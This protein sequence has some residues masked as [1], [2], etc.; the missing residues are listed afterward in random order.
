MQTEGSKNTLGLCHRN[1]IPTISR[2][3]MG[4]R[5]VSAITLGHAGSICPVVLESAAAN[6]AAQAEYSVGA[7]DGPVHPGIVMCLSANCATWC[8][9]RF[10][11]SASGTEKARACGSGIATGCVCAG[12]IR[13]ARARQAHRRRPTLRRPAS[14]RQSSPG[15]NASRPAT[16]RNSQAVFRHYPAALYIDPGPNS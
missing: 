10:R 7:R 1:R 13:G 5:Q 15:W 6:A 12:R 8:T 16:L 3:A 4:A 9:G 14:S 2:T 11:T